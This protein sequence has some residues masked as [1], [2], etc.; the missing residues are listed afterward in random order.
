MTAQPA[1]EP[2]PR[3][4]AD[5]VDDLRG[6]DFTVLQAFDVA[7]IRRL[8]PRAPTWADLEHEIREI[9]HLEARGP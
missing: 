3:P 8:G 9:T 5:Q 6:S 7:G 2:L 4:G 1:Q